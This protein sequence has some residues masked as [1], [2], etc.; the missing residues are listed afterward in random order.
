MIFS[1][2]IPC[3]NCVKTLEATVNSIRACGLTDYE[4]L[5][6]DD[7]SA[8]GTAKLCD[9]LCIRYPELRCVH[10]KNAG[11]SAARNRGIYEAQG[12]YLWFV[13]ADDTVDVG[14]LSDAADTIDR[15]QPD[16]LL[17]GMS[18]DYYRRG[19]LYRRDKLVPPAKGMLAAE[20][21]KASFNDFYARN[22]LT[23]VW[24]KLC[25]KE[26]ILESGTRFHEDMTLMEDF[27]FVLELLPHCR[28]IYSLPDAIYRY[29]QAEDEKSAYYRLQKI[30][31]LA[32]YIQPIADGI[33][34]LQIPRAEAIT[35]KI[36]EMLL[37]QKLYYAP[38]RQIRRILMEQKQ[39]KY[40]SL[41][42]GSPFGI[43][44]RNRKTQLRHRI[45]VAVKSNCLYQKNIRRGQRDDQTPDIY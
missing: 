34:R 39:S 18:F 31:D 23:P 37:R 35:E 8:D 29:R 32:E 20:E 26:T 9:T 33:C 38:L 11:V 4:I 10:Q 22:A 14:A 6:I 25:R 21:L 30:A 17:F 40:A 36:Y 13:D 2:V 15:Q 44:L 19:R 24:N 43:Y 5:L 42:M 1:V 12:E 27:L 41:E 16:M 3:Y 28:T 7:G 45:A